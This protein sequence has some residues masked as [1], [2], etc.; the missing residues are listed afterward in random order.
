MK[1]LVEIT[2]KVGDF[3]YPPHTYYLNKAGKLAG[4]KIKGEKEIKWFEKPLAF[5]RRR[6][7]FRELP[8][9]FE[10]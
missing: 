3:T 6:R 9:E 1:R 4:F 8:C 7:L 10:G 5:D 2:G